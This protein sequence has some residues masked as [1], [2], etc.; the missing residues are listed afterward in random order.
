MPS[1]VYRM[2]DSTPVSSAIVFMILSFASSSKNKTLI[3]SLFTKSVISDRTFKLGS[4]SGDI[5]DKL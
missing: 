2:S 5:P 3:P 4:L 1:M